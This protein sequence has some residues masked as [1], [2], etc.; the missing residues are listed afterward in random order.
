MACKLA[1][2]ER[3]YSEIFEGINLKEFCKKTAVKVQD[4]A[5]EYETVKD[6]FPYIFVIGHS[7]ERDDPK[8]IDRAPTQD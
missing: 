1:V 2:I 5:R 6:Q 3:F 8:A 4:I 7:S